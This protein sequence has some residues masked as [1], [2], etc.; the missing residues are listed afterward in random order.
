MKI[1]LVYIMTGMLFIVGTSTPSAP[2]PTQTIC[3]GQVTVP[4]RTLEA[5]KEAT[6]VSFPCPGL[7][8][9]DSVAFN[10]ASDI[11]KIPGYMPAGN[12]IPSINVIAGAGE[13]WVNE[14]N[15]NAQPI[16]TA[17]LELAVRGLR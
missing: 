5:K 9:I 17:A 12:G 14:A 4:A 2:K 16:T 10:S 8:A 3:A 7:L 1:I 15:V 13:I 11:F 6:P